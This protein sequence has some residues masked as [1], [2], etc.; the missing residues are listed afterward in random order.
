[1]VKRFEIYLLNLDTEISDDARNTRP[2]VVISPDEMNKHISSAIVAPVSSVD[3]KYP[4]RI[5]FEF[6]EKKRAVVLD[7]IRTVEKERLVKNIGTIERSAQ[8]AILDT[9]QEMFAK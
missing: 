4:T 3:Q 5:P 9:L 1:M 8:T 6:L 2:C 7:Q